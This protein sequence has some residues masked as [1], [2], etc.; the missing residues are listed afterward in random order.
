MGVKPIIATVTVATAGTRVQVIA[1]NTY[2]T[3]VYFEALGTAAN[4][5]FIYIG[6]SSVTSSK[7]AS[8]VTTGAGF[9]MSIGGIPQ[10]P[11][12]GNGGPEINLNTIYVDA[13]TS[14]NKVNVSY[15]TRVGNS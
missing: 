7:Y 5:G 13:S 6:D 3:S 15:F 2:V 12:D 8:A 4:T 1:A 11:S 9:S 14:G 10:K